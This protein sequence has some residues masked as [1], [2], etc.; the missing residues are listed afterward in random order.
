[1]TAVKGTDHRKAR[2]EAERYYEVAAETQMKGAE[3]M[4]S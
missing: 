3:I 2:P 4:G 1:M